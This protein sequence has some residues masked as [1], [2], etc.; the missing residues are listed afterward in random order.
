V[1]TAPARASCQ[2]RQ[3]RQQGP[4]ET[5]FHAVNSIDRCKEC[6]RFVRRR[7]AA[8]GFA[9]RIAYRRRSALLPYTTRRNRKPSRPFA[10]SWRAM[11]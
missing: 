8:A 6:A 1:I 2:R 3:D 5:D 4:A 11:Q 9:S 10:I 7:S